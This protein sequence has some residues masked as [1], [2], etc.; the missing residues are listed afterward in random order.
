MKHSK[1][2]TPKD[3]EYAIKWEKLRSEY[4]RLQ[5][6]TFLADHSIK[7]LQEL[8]WRLA[9]LVHKDS[10]Q[11]SEQLTNAGWYPSSESLTNYGWST[12]TKIPASA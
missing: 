8:Q 12:N 9:H 4:F 11:A 2:S 3:Y 1:L 10:D 6:Q 7:H 5:G